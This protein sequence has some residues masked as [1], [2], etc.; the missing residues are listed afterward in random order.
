MNVEPT[1]LA[2]IEDAWW[3]EQTEGYSN[4]KVDVRGSPSSECV[5]LMQR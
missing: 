3:D 5:D 1:I 2:G 4:D